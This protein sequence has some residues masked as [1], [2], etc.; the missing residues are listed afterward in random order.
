M[1]WI[2]P[3]YSREGYEEA[4]PEIWLRAEVARRLVQ[5]AGRLLADGYGLKVLDGWRPLQLQR[6]LRAEY[7]AAIKRES[8]GLTGK[9]LEERLGAFVSPIGGDDPPPHSTGGAVDLTL[10]TTDGAE[11]D[12][13]GSFDE[14]SDRS[15][16]G[17][18][19]GRDLPPDQVEFRDLRRLL[20]AAMAD[21]GFWQFPTEWWHFE[22]GTVSWA[23][24]ANAEPLYALVDTADPED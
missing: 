20:V 16:P 7:G 15:F 5:A 22:Y 13:G 23:R 11:V 2:E 18:Y 24:E 4:L 19:E 10:C 1:I 14:L 6:T 17:Y 9:A 8:P 3:V 21:A 12:M